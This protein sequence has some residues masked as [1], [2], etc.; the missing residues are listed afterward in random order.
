M[1]FEWWRATKIEVGLVTFCGKGHADS[2]QRLPDA[3]ANE[4]CSKTHQKKNQ[5]REDILISKEYSGRV[6]GVLLLVITPAKHTS[7][8][9]SGEVWGVAD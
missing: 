3:L 5:V 7:P 9:T 2:G 1:L 4:L 6:W 8:C